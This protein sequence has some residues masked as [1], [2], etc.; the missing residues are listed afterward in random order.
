[1]DWSSRV[2]PCGAWDENRT[3]EFAAVGFSLPDRF[4]AHGA[5]VKV[6]VR[7]KVGI[8]GEAAD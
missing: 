3:R 7:V 8:R 6:R 1:M 5:G 4:A 2:S